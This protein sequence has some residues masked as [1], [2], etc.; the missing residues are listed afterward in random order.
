MRSAELVELARAAERWLLSPECLLCRAAID[1]RAADPLVCCLCQSRWR[2]VPPPWCERCGQ[3]RRGS[4]PCSLCA[5]WPAVFRLARSA[6]WL[7]GTARHVVHQLKYEGW[8]GAAHSMARA[9]RHLEPLGLDALGRGP[10]LIPVPL[11][12]KRLRTRGYNQAEVLAR[13]VS[14]L[15]GVPVDT[16]AL[17]RVRETRTQTALAPEE[18]AA[19]L[20]GAFRCR[21]VPV[22]RLVLVDDVFTT[23]ATLA[24]A[25]TA[26]GKAG[27]ESVD[28]ITFA[29]ATEPLTASP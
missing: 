13:A 10:V 11:G 25:A 27:A 14:A 2:P 4:D 19:N 23:G 6:V 20:L 7:E 16:G 22:G 21:G 18:R 15:T 17:E 29:R 12:G 8:T 28:A 26:L 3:P 24:A 1:E 9:M 5:A